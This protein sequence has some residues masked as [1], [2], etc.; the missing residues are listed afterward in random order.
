LLRE[1]I[2]CFGVPTAPLPCLCNVQRLWVASVKS[3]RE[4]T[5]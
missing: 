1:M 3:L 4:V 5:L 2:Y